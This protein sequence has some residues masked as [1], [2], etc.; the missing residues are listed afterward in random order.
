MGNYQMQNATASVRH[1]LFINGHI[2]SQM[3]FDF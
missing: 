2:W 3:S 1:D